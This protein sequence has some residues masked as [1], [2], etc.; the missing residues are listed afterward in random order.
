[1]TG[2]DAPIDMTSP[3]P[4][5]VYD[6]LLGGTE[7]FPVDEELARHLLTLDPRAAAAARVNR[8]FTH[9][10]V[11]RLATTGGMRQFLDVGTGIPTEPGLHHT[12]QEH[13]PDARVVYTDNDPAAL[14]H[15]RTLLRSTPQGVTEYLQAD[16]R[17]PEAV[18]EAAGKVL[19]LDRPVVVSLVALLHFVPDEDGP[20][21]LVRR[22]L[23][24]LPS[25]SWLV[26][27]H[28]TADF[29]RNGAERAREVYGRWGLTFAPRSREGFTGFFRGLE[30]AEPGVALAADWRPDPG[31]APVHGA[32]STPAYAGVARKL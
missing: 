5:R 23:A 8:A 22:L 17:E 12:V 28:A 24:P 1:M 25:G 31:E 14:S 21:E 4:A 27:T 15:A 7:N 6:W 10:A 19:D 9:R 13:A 11:R 32:G 2:H 3:H 29:D 18:V 30:L 26:L 20:Y 16:I